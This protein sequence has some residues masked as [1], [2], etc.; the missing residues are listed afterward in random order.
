MLASING[1]RSHTTIA[2]TAFIEV[3]KEEI[4]DGSILSGDYNV[5]GRSSNQNKKSL[6]KYKIEFL[7]KFCIDKFDNGLNA[8]EGWSQCVE[9]INKKLSSLA[10]KYQLNQK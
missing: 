9:A 4:N 7:R 6:D 8:K 3:F 1:C 5:Y 2:T 10:L